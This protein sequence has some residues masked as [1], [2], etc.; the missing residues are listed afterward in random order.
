MLFRRLFFSGVICLSV[1]SIGIIDAFAV[2]AQNALDSEDNE[3]VI[4]SDTQYFDIN[5][6]DIVA[7]A[8]LK[9]L[10]STVDSLYRSGHLRKVHITGSSSPDGANELNKRL[11]MRRAESVA[12]YLSKT[13]TVPGTMTETVSVGENW[14]LF[15]ELLSSGKYPYGGEVLAVIDRSSDPEEC[16]SR[17]R[18]MGNGKVWISLATDVFPMLRTALVTVMADNGSFTVD[19]MGQIPSGVLHDEPAPAEPEVTAEETV[20]DDLYEETYETAV[21]ETTATETPDANTSDE[22]QR[23]LYVKTNAPAWAMLLINA[24]AEIDLDPH[25]SVTLPVYYSGFNYFS[26][27]RKFRTITVIPEG[28]Y[29]FRPDNHGWFVGAHFGFS[30]YNVAFNGDYRYQ[31]HDAKR[32][33]YGG[34]LSVGYRFNFCRNHRW[35]IEVSLGAG[36]YALDY[37]RFRNVHDTD[38]GMLVDRVRRTLFCI[39]TASFSFCYQFDV[40]GGRK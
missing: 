16:E 5:R 9:A 22:W 2:Q 7:T 17:L 40:K 6:S 4:E 28:R 13:T 1:L 29:W 19:S 3:K 11:A 32:P 12:R 31:D 30:F 33:A 14:R 35:K 15:R 39:D 34:G 25:W 37:D 20:I 24:A 10:A 18:S 36:A 26:C 21:A 23:H 27:T 38:R 8:T